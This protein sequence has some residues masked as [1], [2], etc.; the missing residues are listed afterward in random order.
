[1]PRTRL[2]FMVPRRDVDI[3][4]GRTVIVFVR[5]LLLSS[6]T[7]RIVFVVVVVLVAMAPLFVVP[8]ARRNQQRQTTEHSAQL[9]LFIFGWSL[10]VSEATMMLI[11][12]L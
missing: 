5:L 8:L 3:I 2:V 7:G 4:I 11:L 1:M 6:T 9:S 12:S 10:K